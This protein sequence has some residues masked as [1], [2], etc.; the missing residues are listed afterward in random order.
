MKPFDYFVAHSL[1]EA[2]GLLGRYSPDALP[3]AGGTD[4][5]VRMKR[6]QVSPRVLV[7]IAGIPELHGIEVTEQ[8]LHIGSMV[9]HAEIVSSPLIRQHA[10][11]LA[12]ASASVGAPQ[13]RNLGTIGGNLTSCVPSM[14][15]APPL[16]V[17]E[18]LVT[19]AQAEGRR[20]VRLE[21]FFVAPRCS[22]LTPEQLLV[23]VLIPTAHL[24][25]AAG[26]AKFGRRK[27]LTLALVNAAALAEL[28]ETGRRFARPR[29]ALGA[30]AP[31]PIR[32]RK[33]EAFLEG[34]PV[35]EEILKQA[36]VIA[37]EEAKPIDDF[38]ASAQFRRELIKV[39][40]CRVFE[41]ALDG[42]TH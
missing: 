29:L 26:F 12:D 1:D 14:D 23:E 9:T 24:R 19:V 10:P 18:A 22:I 3:I 30:V 6:N 13:T 31:T 38:R 34:K 32:A 36:G 4:L 33:A 42:R 21:E 20:Q 15:G 17:L 5:L 8:G 11:V 40:T 2:L 28:D 27:A 41:K 39:L 37:S 35:A 16:L 25:K 7:D